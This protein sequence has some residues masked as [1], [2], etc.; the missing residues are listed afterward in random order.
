MASEEWRVGDRVTL[1]ADVPALPV[2][3]I[4]ITEESRA[5]VRWDGDRER[6]YLY[7]ALAR[8]GGGDG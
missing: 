4:I 5:R 6:W 2:G 1:A 8:E 3:E 7:N